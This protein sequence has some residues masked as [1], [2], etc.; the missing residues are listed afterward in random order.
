MNHPARLH[1][2]AQGWASRG[3]RHRHAG[4]ANCRSFRVANVD[5][6]A[7][8]WLH[9]PHQR[10]SEGGQNHAGSEDGRPRLKHELAYSWQERHR[11]LSVSETLPVAS[12]SESG[13]TFPIIPAKWRNGQLMRGRKNSSPQSVG[14]RSQQPTENAPESKLGGVLHFQNQSVRDGSG[15]NDVDTATPD[16]RVRVSPLSTNNVIAQAAVE[17][18][19]SGPAEQRVVVVTAVDGVA[20]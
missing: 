1:G 12:N 15:R 9:H 10:R 19:Q 13:S 14:Q 16:N 11:T 7:S 3:K 6:L 20:A 17:R 8:S 4:S 5:S 18:I 2:T